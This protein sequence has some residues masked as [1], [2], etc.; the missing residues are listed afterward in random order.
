M[1]QNPLAFV[2]L[3]TLGQR[4][5]WIPG[6]LKEPQRFVEK[7]IQVPVWLNIPLIH[8]NSSHSFDSIL[9]AVPCEQGAHEDALPAYHYEHLTKVNRLT[10]LLTSDKSVENGMSLC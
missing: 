4:M 7:N 1:R 8:L 6:Q 10:T 9:L 5:A 3:G 2:N